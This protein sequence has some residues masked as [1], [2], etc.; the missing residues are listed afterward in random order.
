MGDSGR[1][2]ARI[3]RVIG[4]CPDILDLELLATGRDDRAEPEPLLFDDTLGGFHQSPFHADIG[5]DSSI[6]SPSCLLSASSKRSCSAAV[7][8]GAGP[9]SSTIGWNIFRL[10]Q[11]AP[12]LRRLDLGAAWQL[13][14]PFDSNSL[15]S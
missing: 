14:T 2:L 9:A 10:L 13:V 11:I 12:T 4:L 7:F 8:E 15:V 5:G 1:K 3:M 6:C